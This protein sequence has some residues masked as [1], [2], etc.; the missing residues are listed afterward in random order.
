[1]HWQIQPLL[2]ACNHMISP[3]A[4]VQR[5]LIQSVQP[6]DLPAGSSTAQPHMHVPTCWAT[7]GALSGQQLALL[8]KP[9]QGLSSIAGPIKRRG[10]F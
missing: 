3:Q 4:A 8:K 7:G 10:N 6:Y 2:L 1:M 5:N 9:K